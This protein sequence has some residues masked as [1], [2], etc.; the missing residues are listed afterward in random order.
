MGF[1]MASSYIL[2]LL[3][4]AIALQSEWLSLIK[5]MTTM[6]GEAESLKESMSPVRI[7]VDSFSL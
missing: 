5:Q 4:N 2:K 1:S 7:A 3:W 6:V